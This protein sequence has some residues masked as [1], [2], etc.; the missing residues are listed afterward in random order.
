MAAATI[1]KISTCNFFKRFPFC[2]A[3][4]SSERLVLIETVKTYLNID[5]LSIPCFNFLEPKDIK[6]ALD[7]F[8]QYGQDLKT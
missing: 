5:K 6:I 4:D 2:T 3:L 1:E 8:T 7:F